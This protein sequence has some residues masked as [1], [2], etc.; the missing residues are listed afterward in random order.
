MNGIEQKLTSYTAGPVTTTEEFNAL[1]AE[2][3]TSAQ[4]CAVPLGGDA[5]LCNGA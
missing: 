3:G 5:L 4:C 1:C 2:T